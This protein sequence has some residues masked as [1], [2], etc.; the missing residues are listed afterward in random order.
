MKHENKTTLP[1]TT[2]TAGPPITSNR[3]HTTRFQEK[4]MLEHTNQ[5]QVLISE[6]S[7]ETENVYFS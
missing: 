1:T 5:K 6:G 2:N 7:V 4:K 3:K